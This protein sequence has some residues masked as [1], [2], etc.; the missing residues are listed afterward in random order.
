VDLPRP[1]A[2]TAQNAG[3]VVFASEGQYRATY[4]CTD[5]KGAATVVYRDVR[6]VSANAPVALRLSVQ[7]PGS[8]D[9][10]VALAPAPEVRVVNASGA[11]LTQAGTAISVVLAGGSGSFTGT[12][13]RLTDANGTAR[14]DDLAFAGLSAGTRTLAF[15]SP[16]LAGAASLPIEVR[17]GPPVGMVAVSLTDQAGRTGEAVADPPAV[18]LWDAFGN[19]VP[20]APVMFTVTAGGGTLAGTPALSGADGVAR[21][22]SWKLET[23]GPQ[24]VEATATGLTAVTFTATRPP[25]GR[26]RRRTT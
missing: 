7:P 1:A 14:F 20:G 6:V 24:A 9:I 21:L 4:A 25:R 12:T 22:G 3:S 26:R 2:S 19:Q 10:S 8:A 15:T 16:G 17:A 5:E 11:D 18:R 13:T 23:P